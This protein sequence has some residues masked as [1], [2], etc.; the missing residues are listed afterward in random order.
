M[1]SL[2]ERS[3]QR[4]Y[5]LRKKRRKILQRITAVFVA[6][7]IIGSV[8]FYVFF[9]MNRT[10]NGYTVV[11]E[12]ERKDSNS[13]KYLYHKGKL[14]K[15]SK[16]GASMLT[17]NGE[18]IWNGSYEYQ[19]P[20]AVAC[21]DYVVVADQGG[22]QFSVFNEKKE[23]VQ[24]KVDAEIEQ[25]A[26]ADQ[27]VVAVT[28]QQDDEAKINIYDPYDVMEQL[29]VSIA[30][31]TDSDGYPVGIALSE[32]GQRL[33]TSY[34]NIA[35]GVISSS[36]NFYNFSV[37]GKNKVDRIV[38]SR[39]MEQNIIADVQFLNSNTVCAFGEKGFY[40]YN[41]KDTPDDVGKIEFKETIRSVCYNS[42]Y[43]GVVAENNGKFD[44]A[45]KLLVYDLNGKQILEK[46]ID[47]TYDKVEFGEEEV[48]FYSS[49]QVNILRFRGSQ[50]L[51][52]D[53]DETAAY[54]FRESASD[55][56]ILINGSKIQEVR[57][58]G[59]KKE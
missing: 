43:I 24:I 53:F 55:K 57:L 52:C 58:T 33:V 23:T 32:D 20:I 41:M 46:E 30:T 39:P 22:K 28:L 21:G 40:L 35:G 49:M 31:S 25:I 44:K 13:A 45:Y 29:K 4:R 18:I 34:V 56:Y 47:Y 50:K 12:I 1:E 14:I 2:S 8:L 51:C 42:K 7:S 11:N 5:E 48:I 54:F 59:R 38:G 6:V 27:G 26:V 9:Q 36:L 15:Y 3:E 16:D 10:Y 17:A 19:N 37:T